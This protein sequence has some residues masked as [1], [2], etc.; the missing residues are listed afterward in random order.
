MQLTRALAASHGRDGLCATA[1][2]PG[3]FPLD[4]DEEE[5]SLLGERQVAGRVGRPEEVGPLVAFLASDAS[6]YLNGITISLDGG[7][8]AGGLVPAGIDLGGAAPAARGAS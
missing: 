5:R 4:A 7:A 8:A 1:V 2:A 3:L 6:A